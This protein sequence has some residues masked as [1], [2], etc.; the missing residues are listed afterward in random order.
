MPEDA[1]ALQYF[2]TV[3]DRLLAPRETWGLMAAVLGS[4]RNRHAFRELF[5]WDRDAGLYH[6]L[7]FIRPPRPGQHASTRRKDPDRPIIRY[8]H[9]PDNPADAQV[10]WQMARQRFRAAQTAVRNHTT[11]LQSVWDS[12]VRDSV[13][14]RRLRE[15]GVRRE[16]HRARRPGWLARIFRTRRYR[17]WRQVGQEIERDATAA[18]HAHAEAGQA[19]VRAAPLL[20]RGIKAAPPTSSDPSGAPSSADWFE[21]V[22]AALGDRVMDRNFA[23]AG[24]AEQ[25]LRTPWFD[26]HGHRLRD[27]L[28]VA[29]MQ[30]HRAF[31][32]GAA[33]QLRTNLSL[34]MDVFAGRPVIFDTADGCA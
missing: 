23:A 16:L 10:R 30:L 28:F 27:D 24:H 4:A 6:Y 18:E 33:Q 15:L 14:D 26:E 11:Q 7:N 32:D 20:L 22:R 12:M 34:L 21:A 9:P 29:A 19:F 5:W 8:E 2:K 25:Q 17:E 31:I 13:R 1:P 3:S